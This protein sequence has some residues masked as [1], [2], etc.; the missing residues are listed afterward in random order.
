MKKI[1]LFTALLLPFSSFAQVIKDKQEAS[2]KPDHYNVPLYFNPD[3]VGVKKVSY[4][5]SWDLKDKKVLQMGSLSLDE[6]SF[7]PAFF[8]GNS[9][10]HPLSIAGMDGGSKDTLFLIWP[11][12]VIKFGTVEMIARDGTVL[13]SESFN[14]DDY[15]SWQKNLQKAK[16][17]NPEEKQK[18][19]KI[20]FVS[21]IALKGLTAEILSK[22]TSS[23][24]F[25]L[26]QQ[27]EKEHSMLCTPK[28]VVTKKDGSLT[29]SRITEQLDARVLVD[30]EEVPLSGQKDVQAGQLISFFSE[31]ATG[32]SYEF[33]THVLPLNLFDIFK[34]VDGA[35]LISGVDPVPFGTGVYEGKNDE[36]NF[37]N[38]WG[39]QQTIGD[40]RS[41]WQMQVPP[42][43]E[44]TFPGKVGG[45]FRL[46]LDFKD[47]PT[48]SERVWGSNK[49]VKVTYQDKKVL[50]VYHTEKQQLKGQSPQEVV[51]AADTP[52]EAIWNFPAPKVG[53]YNLS[54]LEVTEGSKTNK[55]SSEVYRGRSSELSGRFTAAVD[56]NL[57]SILLGEVSY[58]KWFE[59]LWDW[60]NYKWSNLR[61]G[62]SAK[63]FK[64]L[65]SVSVKEKSTSASASPSQSAEISVMSANLKYRLN[66]G[67]WGRDETWGLL[68][69]YN[70]IS[71]A[72]VNAPVL[73]VGFF[74]ARSMPKVFDD[75]I[76]HVWF[77]N[78]PK[79]V[80]MEVIYLPSSM[81][82]NVSLGSSYLVNFHGKVLWTETVFGEAG[83]GLQSYSLQDKAKEINVGLSSFYLTVGLGL[84]F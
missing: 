22:T 82:S 81:D 37:W 77:M 57:Q 30:K 71:I 13:W 48:A 7:V 80:D 54:R 59:N 63:Y 78:Y 68:G 21:G 18:S 64:S 65:N 33:Q 45:A 26:S 58:N 28:H 9:K 27:N 75:L 24:R 52:N 41:Y 20:L 17:Q 32:L 4:Q 14:Y 72:D 76:S 44:L 6:N 42:N 60:D 40:L 1:V 66:P 53:D 34:D 23:F 56:K 62:V 3:D 69:G 8:P 31:T 12:Q 49:D 36:E 2:G 5:L 50:H 43:K 11:S 74:W 55:L 84:N 29:L 15:K 35:V 61:W 70:S 79:F 19:N 47:I 39:W 51:Q 16:L 73:G 25:C 46:Q 67:L 10:D 83:F 38:K